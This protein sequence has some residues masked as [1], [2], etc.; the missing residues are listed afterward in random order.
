MKKL[1]QILLI[2]FNIAGVAY[3]IVRGYQIRNDMNR[4]LEK[5]K[6]RMIEE[7]DTNVKKLGIIIS[8]SKVEADMYIVKRMLWNNQIGLDTYTRDELRKSIE[9]EVGRKIKAREKILSGGGG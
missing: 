8:F 5:E 3:F 2:L 6:A 7:F 9:Y 4:E 1:G